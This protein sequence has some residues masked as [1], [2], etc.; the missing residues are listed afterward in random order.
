M[1][2]RRSFLQH[3]IEFAVTEAA[4]KGWSRYVI[5][6]YIGKGDRTIGHTLGLWIFNLVCKL[7]EAG[8]K[9]VLWGFGV[10]IDIE[11]VYTWMV[12][13]HC[14]GFHSLWSVAWKFKDAKRYEIM[15]YFT[16]FIFAYI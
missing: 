11:S 12:I 5:Y 16:Y 6:P 2:F 7:N 13:C 3:K 14:G 4:Q 1:G 15:F 8:V 10:K 9:R